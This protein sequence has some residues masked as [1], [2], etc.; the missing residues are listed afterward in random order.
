MMSNRCVPTLT[1]SARSLL[2]S[3][4]A[5]NTSRLDRP[6][7]GHRS[8]SSLTAVALSLSVFRF[9]DFALGIRTFGIAID[10]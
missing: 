3:N 6:A 4:F 7:S 9:I 2:I 1:F 10:R 5:T 8:N